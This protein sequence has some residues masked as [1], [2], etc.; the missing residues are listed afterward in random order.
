MLFAESHGDRKTFELLWDWTR[1]S[2]RRDDGLF[3][4]RW[5]PG[6]A[7]PVSDKN[8]AADGDLLIAWALARAARRWNEPQWAA[9]SG[10]IAAAILHNLAVEIDGRLLLLP[11]IDGFRQK[12]EATIN[13]S[14]YVWPAIDELVKATPD[15]RWR[16]L[17]SDGLWLLDNA[18]FGT[19]ALPPDWMSFGPQASRIATG[20]PPQFGYEAVRIPLYLAWRGERARLSRFIT[21]WHATLVGGRPPAFIDLE[22]G[23]LPGYTA[24]G[25]FAAVLELA[26]LAANG[27]PGELP[28]AKLTD[29]DDYYA[30]SLKMLSALAATEAFPTR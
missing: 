6:V 21:A 20:W 19:H 3:S 23:A 13:L 28:S 8:D 24:S 17:A 14:Y 10:F 16:R 30:A 7:T 2:L 29:E 22:T 1:R 18:T 15:R 27:A 4:W 5:M 25:G 26:Q 11:G 12:D 9:Q